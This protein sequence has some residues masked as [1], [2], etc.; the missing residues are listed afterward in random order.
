MSIR[1]KILLSYVKQENQVYYNLIRLFLSAFALTVSCPHSSTNFVTNFS[2]NYFFSSSSLLNDNVIK[3][4]V[5]DQ[6]AGSSHRALG[7]AFTKDTTVT[8][9]V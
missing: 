4:K 9:S 3:C 2:F 6:R 1:L 7:Q 5:L 8:P